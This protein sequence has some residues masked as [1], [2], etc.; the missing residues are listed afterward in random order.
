[1]NRS[2]G[3]TP[4][5]LATYRD[6][7]VS[8]VVI[9]AMLFAGVIIE[10]LPATCWQLAISAYYYT[11]AHSIVI[12]ALLALGTLFIVHRGSSDTEDVLLTLAGVAA[13]IAAMVPQGRPEKLCGPND[14]KS[15]FV[16]AI[17]PNVWAVVIALILGWF[18][19][20]L[21]HLCTDGL[22]KR[23]PVGTLIRV[24]FYLIM[25]SGLI[26]LWRF[27]GW[28][29]DNAHGVAGFV[30]LSAFIATVFVA[31]YVVPRIEG[32]KA[33]RGH[34]VYVSFYKFIAGLMLLTLIVVVILHIAFPKWGLWTLLIEAALIFE[35]AVYWV[36]QTLELWDTPDRRE[37]LPAD[38][39]QRIADWHTKGGLRGLR[40]A[41]A[42]FR[43]ESG[44]DNR[45]L[46][47]L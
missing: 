7:R 1:M 33:P 43:N 13:L 20:G 38:T 36:A 30:L 19:M 26:A 31:A 18:I 40:A 28:F 17:E 29:N 32:S 10:K 44:D 15:D 12:A 4:N 42:D 35:F 37:R 5:T 11:T 45:L 8:G 27:P 16:P 34:A 3:P 9:M 21:I 47:Y 25:V 2:N 23:S 24:L 41:L 46:P 22:P 14:L 39:R 6:V